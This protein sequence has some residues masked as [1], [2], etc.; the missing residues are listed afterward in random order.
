M[1]EYAEQL[2]A[3]VV[4]MNARLDEVD[5]ALEEA[6]SVE[7]A[8]QLW[9]QR[10]AAREGFVAFLESVDPPDGA[11]ELHT[12]GVDILGRLAAAEGAMADLADDY[13]T[14]ASLGQIWDT[15]AG[16]AARAVDGE[17]VVIC[18]AA[19]ARFDETADRGALEDVS[20]VTAEMKDIIDVVFGCIGEERRG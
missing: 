9:E 19:Q 2:E 12:N 7:Q 18:Q 3:E 6:E 1:A 17:A 5:A 13:D 10:I 20:W 4:R 14:V 8:K 15:P 11:T 16:Q